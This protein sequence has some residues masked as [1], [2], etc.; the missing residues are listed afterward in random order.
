MRTAL[1]ALLIAASAHADVFRILDD[2]RDAAQARVSLHAK[3]MV[4]DDRIVLVG[5]YNVDP[6]SHN[7]NSEV[8]CMADDAD[9]A[10]ALLDAIDVHIR[11]AWRVDTDGSA[12]SEEFPG[13]RSK[14]F[15]AWAMR[16]I[17]P[18]I[19]GQL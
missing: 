17:V 11:N 19:E 4:I 5:S 12:P 18:V 3:S 2:P 9:T 16:F 1:L 6:R 10:R 7:L 14:S 13:D 8:M 15:R